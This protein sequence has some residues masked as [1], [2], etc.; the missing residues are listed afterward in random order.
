[1]PSTRARKGGV[2]GQRGRILDIFRQI[3]QF[4]PETR[5]PVTSSSIWALV[6]ISYFLNYDPR[7]QLRTRNIELCKKDLRI[8]NFW[9]RIS[10]K[11]LNYQE[12]IN[13]YF[14]HKCF[15]IVK[16]LAFEILSILLG[17]F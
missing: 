14:I 3:S 2:T 17:R 10:D 4:K 11:S 1:M 7:I 9:K 6:S 8:V 13:S 5:T 16:V 12:T 15:I